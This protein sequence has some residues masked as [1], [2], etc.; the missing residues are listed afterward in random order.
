MAG[1]ITA[2]V[3]NGAPCCV[4]KPAAICCTGTGEIL[5]F[6]GPE[7]RYVLPNSPNDGN[8]I[9]VMLPTTKGFIA[10]CANGTVRVFEK[11]ADPK[12]MFKRSKRFKIADEISNVTAL[13]VSPSEDS[14]V[15]TLASGQAYTLSLANTDLGKVSTLYPAHGACWSHFHYFHR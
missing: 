7:F 13:A 1:N 5:F 6:E 4:A 10:G 8:A 12:E 15:C 14:L 9:F 2:S 11:A 3:W